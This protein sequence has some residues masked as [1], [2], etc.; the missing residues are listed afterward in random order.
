MLAY[1]TS[2]AKKYHH[3]S[4]SFIMG[5]EKLELQNNYNVEK[6]ELVKVNSQEMKQ[7]VQLLLSPP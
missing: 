5:F 4:V 3:Y 6:G 1:S 7:S 2:I